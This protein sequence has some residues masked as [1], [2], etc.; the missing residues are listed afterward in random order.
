MLKVIKLNVVM[1]NVI[2]LNA[3][4]LNVVM[5]SVVMLNVVMLNVVMMSVVMLSVVAPCLRQRRRFL[6][7]PT[8]NRIIWI[9]RN[10]YN[11]V[12]CFHISFG[13]RIMFSGA[14]PFGQLDVSSNTKKKA[15]L[16]IGSFKLG[17][18]LSPLLTSGLYY[19]HVTLVIYNHSHNDLWPVL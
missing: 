6:D 14:R 18:S 5:L 9:W 2:M 19:K 10:A 17:S 13:M 16:S 8:K 4:M 1:L 7:R 3:I 15:S 11:T 12:S